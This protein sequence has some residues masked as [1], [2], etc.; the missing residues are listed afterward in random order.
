MSNSSVEDIEKEYQSQFKKKVDL[1]AGMTSRH[2]KGKL[3]PAI[4]KSKQKNERR[5]RKKNRK[6]VR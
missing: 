4:R 5:R 6:S 1:F 3:P 2:R